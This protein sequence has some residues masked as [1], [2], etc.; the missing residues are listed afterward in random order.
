MEMSPEAWNEPQQRTLILRRAAADGDGRVTILTL[1]LNPTDDTRRFRLPL[2]RL[3]CM[4]LLDTAAP[5]LSSR[6]VTGGTLSVGAHSAILVHAEA[7]A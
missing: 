6:A 5:E 7:A 4:I 3:A 2:P 1:L